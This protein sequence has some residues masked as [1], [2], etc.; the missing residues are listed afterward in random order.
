MMKFGYEREKIDISVDV[1][2]I[3]I[4]EA[5]ITYK[6]GHHNGFEAGRMEGILEKHTPNQ[7]REI[8]GLNHV[9]EDFY[10]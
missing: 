8:L 9:M 7:I 5:A 3:E 2:G 6:H 4:C 10:E 1:R